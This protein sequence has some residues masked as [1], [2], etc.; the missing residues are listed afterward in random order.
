MEN[1]VKDIK[2]SFQKDKM[3]ARALFMVF[4]LVVYSISKFLI[5]GLALFQLITLLLTE[6]PN[7]QVLKFSQNLSF[8]IYQIIKYV[9][10]NSELKPFP[11]SSWPNEKMNMAESDPSEGMD[12]PE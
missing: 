8:Y 11:F 6:K 5:I 1:Q 3:V 7:E 12:K 4:F 2:Q 9:S 10:F